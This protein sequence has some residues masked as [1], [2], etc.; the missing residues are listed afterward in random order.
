[1]GLISEKIE[2][3]KKRKAKIEEQGENY[4]SDWNESEGLSNLVI[5][6]PQGNYA[7]KSV[8]VKLN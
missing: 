2:E 5:N 4:I 7:G 8:T 6:L 3:L 1:M